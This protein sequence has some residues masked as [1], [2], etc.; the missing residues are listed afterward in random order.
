[1]ANYFPPTSVY[2]KNYDSNYNLFLVYNTSETITTADNNPW[3]SE[4]F[5][6]SVAENANEIWATNGYAN[7]EGELF[8]YDGVGYDSF[9]KINQFKRC[10]RNIGGTH[11]KFN[12]TGSEVRGFV[13][14]EHQEQIVNTILN[15]ENFV[16]ENFSKDAKTLDWRI[17]HLQQLPDIF[18]DFSCP[19]VIFD[20]YTVSNNPS[21]GI[22]IQYQVTIN[23]VF[24]SYRL[25]FGDGSYTTSSTSG[26]HIYSPNATIDPIVTVYNTNCTIVQSPIVRSV[27]NEPTAPVTNNGL[28]FEIPTIPTLPSF[29][30][31]IPAVPSSIVQI[32]PI[33]FPNLEIGSIIS[34]NTIPSIVVSLITT[35]DFPSS[36]TISP[37]NIPTLITI[38]NPEFPTNIT[39][40]PPTIPTL[41]GFGPITIP[42]FIGFGPI[43]EFP[44]NIT[45][46]PPT[47]PTFIGFGPISI[48]T[49]ISFDPV[50]FPSTVS[51]IVG[52]TIPTIIGFTPVSFPSIVSFTP[53]SFPS[54]VSFTPVNIPTIISFG[55][56]TFPSVI[57][58]VVGVNIPTV[59]TF[60]PVNIP[61]YITFGPVTIPT[62]IAFAPTNIPTSITFGP[63]TL[64]NT[65]NFAPVSFPLV[66]F[67]PISFPSLIVSV[68]IPTSI[69]FGPNNVPTKIYFDYFDSV[70][71][72][73]F[74][75]FDYFAGTVPSIISFTNPGI[76]TLIYFGPAPM[77]SVIWGT[78]P[79]VSC[80]VTISCPSSTSMI[81]QKVGVPDL[82]DGL[83]MNQIDPIEVQMGDLGIPS[84]IFVRMPEIPD[85]RIIHDV[86][87]FIRV[88]APNIPDI[89]IIESIPRE[90][91]VVGYNIPTSIEL[92][93]TNVPKSIKLESNLPS[94]IKFDMPKEFPNI[95][96][97][98]TNIPSTIQV[99]GF[100]PSIELKGPSE[101]KL[102]LPEKQEIELV[103]KGAPVEF[104]INLDV[105]RLTGED[106]SGSCVR[107]VPCTP[108]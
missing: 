16:G 78:P 71:L 60:S 85:I 42:T 50:T 30:I 24:T 98:V 25:D 72:P 108:N 43:A 107:I 53:V 95:K 99:V 63:V 74:I 14:A 47:I 37:V 80:I 28:Q 66:Y 91:K 87:Q 39:F 49:I 92:M 12:P 100:P 54:I 8:Y 34:A 45:F 77:L 38:T 97:D 89:K 103:Y 62:L 20:Y 86:P 67:A 68:N 70:E 23:G 13:I 101:I 32:P 29:N 36:I 75:Y 61:T 2:P 104:K 93:A 6:K 15:I 105:G 21:T 19:N 48:P 9:G 46:S 3:S 96:F 26:T 106:G 7:I 17:R 94:Y 31:P 41:I 1:M 82:I 51:F 10:A 33:I 5:I 69:S 83:P 84:E 88:E 76:P 4:I 52:L 58:F 64:P 81:G 11:T 44:T 55:P 56:V 22:I 57:S 27:A 102:T 79:Q 65:I 59:I 35:V 90:I 40:S 18:D 73:N